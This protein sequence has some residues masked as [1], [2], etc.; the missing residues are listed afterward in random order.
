[1]CVCVC[2]GG[3]GRGDRE[4]REDEEDEGLIGR[5]TETLRMEGGG[6]VVEWEEGGW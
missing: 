1:M 2:V 5:G 4:E 6:R 3:E